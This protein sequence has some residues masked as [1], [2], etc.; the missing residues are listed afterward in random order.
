MRAFQIKFQAAV[1]SVVTSTIK[2]YYPH[3]TSA[4]KEKLAKGVNRAVWATYDGSPNMDAAPRMEK[5]ARA[6]TQPLVDYFLPTPEY[7]SVLPKFQ[8]T[9]SE[10]LFERHQEMT[11]AFLK[12]TGKDVEFELPAAG[13]LGRTSAIY[14]YIRRDLGVRMHGAENFSRFEGGLGAPETTAE[15]GRTIGHNV[16]TIYEAIRDGKMTNILV[17]MFEGVVGA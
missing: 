5:T 12:P 6:S 15:N 1:S 2:Q 17:G 7:L 8:T 10:K 9:L 14:T 16:S 13:L 4:E 11:A 3:L